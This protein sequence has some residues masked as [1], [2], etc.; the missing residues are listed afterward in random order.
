MLILLGSNRFCLLIGSLQVWHSSKQLSPASFRLLARISQKQ[1]FTISLVYH[2]LCHTQHAQPTQKRSDDVEITLSTNVSQKHTKQISIL[3]SSIVIQGW[4]HHRTQNQ[5]LEVVS[6]TNIKQSG[7]GTFSTNSLAT[8]LAFSKVISS[9]KASCSREAKS[10]TAKA[11]SP[12][13]METC[14]V[15]RKKMMSAN[16][17]EW[18]VNGHFYTNVYYLLNIICNH[19][20]I[21]YLPIGTQYNTYI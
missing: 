9:G 5:M 14:S 3:P 2:C 18:R 12:S 13:R 19:L 4:L 17:V 21:Y 16:P 20:K 11:R 6:N 10:S 8:R 15:Q 7:Q 1:G